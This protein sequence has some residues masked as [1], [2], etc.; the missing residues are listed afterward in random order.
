MRGPAVNS[1]KSPLAYD[2]L[3]RAARRR[4]LI[5]PIARAL[6]ITG[7]ISVLYFILP[8]NPKSAAETGVALSIELI[9][10]AALLAWHVREIARSPY[11]QVR[12]LEAVITAFPIFVLVFATA[13]FVMGETF[14]GSYSEAMTRLDALYFSVTVFSTVGFGDITAVTEPARIVT[15]VQMVLGVVL[16]GLVVRV[17]YQ[18]VQVG[19]ARRD[20]GS[21]QDP[22]DGDTQ[23]S[24]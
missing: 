2:R 1:T 3:P 20:R 14:K 22:P 8:F 9:A 24:R 19:L 4:A 5:V 7:A 18:S 17:L 16:I 21:D 10:L 23:S 11:P 13:Y 12:A 6:G 15:T